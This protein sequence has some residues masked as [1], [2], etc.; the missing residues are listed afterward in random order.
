MKCFYNIEKI[1]GRIL[2]NA[3]L[4]R[5]PPNPLWVKEFAFG[6]LCQSKR[7]LSWDID[8]LIAMFQVHSSKEVTTAVL[9]PTH[10][11][12]HGLYAEICHFLRFDKESI[13]CVCKP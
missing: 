4:L 9:S 1:N 10:F 7:L 8:L 2:V 3:C 12:P 13:I 5:R 11:V 6:F